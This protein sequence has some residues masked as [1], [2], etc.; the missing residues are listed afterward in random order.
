VGEDLEE[1]SFSQ[2]GLAKHFMESNER[3]ML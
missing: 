3:F 1:T 2:T